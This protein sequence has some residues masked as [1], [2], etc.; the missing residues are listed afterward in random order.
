MSLR[1]LCWARVFFAR[2]HV[3][4]VLSCAFIARRSKQAASSNAVKL[5]ICQTQLPLL[6]A[7]IVLMLFVYL[8]VVFFDICI[9]LP[10]TF[11]MPPNM[12]GCTCTKLCSALLVDIRRHH[13]QMRTHKH[14]ARSLYRRACFCAPVLGAHS[15]ARIRKQAI[16]SSTKQHTCAWYC[17]VD[18]MTWLTC[19]TAELC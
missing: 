19:G 11:I 16:Y 12:Y 1:A 4:S 6:L 2:L 7:Y 5:N 3:L 10:N 9:Y 13:R 14:W 8:C 15:F 17:W 18:G